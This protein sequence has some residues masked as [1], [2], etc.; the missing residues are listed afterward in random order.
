M[1][2]KPTDSATSPVVK[3]TYDTPT[4]DDHIKLMAGSCRTYCTIMKPKQCKSD[5]KD[6]VLSQ[7]CQEEFFRCLEESRGFARW[8]NIN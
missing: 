6:D 2:T 8:H 7:K 3:F 1:S 4:K 5:A